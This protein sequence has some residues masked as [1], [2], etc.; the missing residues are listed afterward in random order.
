M[1]FSKNLLFVILLLISCNE[2]GQLKFDKTKWDTKDD[3]EFPYRNKM[4]N[5][6]TTNY[7]LVGLKYREILKLL[8]EPDYRDTISFGYRLIEDFGSDIDP[9]YSKNLAFKLDK[10]SIITSYKIE[11]WKK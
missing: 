8:G 6:L 11:E 9:I 1:H 10:D 2:T 3:I 7:K 5:D 4:L